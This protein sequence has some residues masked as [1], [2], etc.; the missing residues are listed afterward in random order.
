MKKNDVLL[1]L[2]TGIFSGL[3]Y[4]QAPGINFLLLTLLVTLSATYLN[5]FSLKE[6]RRWYYF[7]AANTSGAAV[8]LINSDLSILACIVSLLV[9]SSKLVHKE[10]SI[11]A[12]GFFAFY[13]IVSSLFYWILALSSYSNE[14]EK[15]NA[16]NKWK[17]GV[18]LFLSM[19]VVIFFLIYIKTQ[20]PSSTNL[21]NSSILIG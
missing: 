18:G 16:R 1:L 12:N 17:N 11:L 19:L 21:L 15:T 6:N 3:F 2:S 20:T 8:F 14:Q 9:F 7:A 5:S 10:N 13:S 4:Q